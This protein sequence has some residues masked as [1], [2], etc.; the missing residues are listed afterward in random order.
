MNHWKRIFIVAIVLIGGTAVFGFWAKTQ[1]DTVI[2]QLIKTDSQTAVVAKTDIIQDQSAQPSTTTIEIASTTDIVSTTTQ[3]QTLT[4]QDTVATTTQSI[5]TAQEQS[6]TPKLVPYFD[7]I[8]FQLSPLSSTNKLHIGCSY[9]LK[10]NAPNLLNSANLWIVNAETIE[11]VHPT[12][13]G[14]TLSSSEPVVSFA[15]NIGE[16]AT[17]TYYI[18]ISKVNDIEFTYRSDKFYIDQKDS[19]VGC[20]TL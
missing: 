20:P 8:N 18:L 19:S 2:S 12:I 6:S 11:K 16:V 10:W 7:P 1:F 17:G 4:I 9:D 3:I 14:L 5:P 15:W 13:S